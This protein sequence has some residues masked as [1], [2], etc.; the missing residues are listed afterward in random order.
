MVL[1]WP[2]LSLQEWLVLVLAA[3]ADLKAA[4]LENELLRTSIPD[5]LYADGI[6]D[7]YRPVEDGIGLVPLLGSGVVNA[8]LALN[9]PRE[10]QLLLLW[11]LEPDSVTAG[12]GVIAVNSNLSLILLLF[13]LILTLFHQRGA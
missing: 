2:R 10:S 3:E 1:Q 7:N 8:F 5:Q 4:D 6:N 9:P 12:C 13:P 11:P